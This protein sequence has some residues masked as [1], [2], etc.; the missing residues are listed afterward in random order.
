[1]RA[2]HGAALVEAIAISPLVMPEIAHPLSGRNVGERMAK[3]FFL[4]VKEVSTRYEQIVEAESADEAYEM[5]NDKLLKEVG[6]SKNYLDPILCDEEG[7]PI[8]EDE[9]DDQSE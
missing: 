8:E 1:M 2:S 7:Q 3:K 4:L 9:D 6:E 5:F